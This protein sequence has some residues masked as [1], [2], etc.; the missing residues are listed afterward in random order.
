MPDKEKAPCSALAAARKTGDDK[1]GKEF[2]RRKPTKAGISASTMSLA[3]ADISERRLQQSASGHNALERGEERTHHTIP[4]LEQKGERSLEVKDLITA[5]EDEPA[6]D[7]RRK[8]L[9]RR[10]FEELQGQ[11]A[12]Y[13]DKFEM[14]KYWAE[15][16]RWPK[17]YF[18]RPPNTS[19]QSPSETLVLHSSSRKRRGE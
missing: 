6:Q 8:Y 11:P 14:I 9:W 5:A 17:R 10:A 16:G 12:I 19:R 1:V 18:E 4:G 13:S 15:H 7:R 3:H 2:P